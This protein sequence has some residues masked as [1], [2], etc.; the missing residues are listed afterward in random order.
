[1]TAQ[2]ILLQAPVVGDLSLMMLPYE[3]CV[4]KVE[5]SESSDR[6]VKR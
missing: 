4:K 3:D 6:E 5:L 1:M 2:D